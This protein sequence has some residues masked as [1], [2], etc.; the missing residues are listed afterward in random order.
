MRNPT[1]WADSTIDTLIRLAN[2]LNDEITPILEGAPDHRRNSKLSAL[3]S[4]LDG[5][6]QAAF[7]LKVALPSDEASFLAQAL[8][9]LTD[10]ERSFLDYVNEERVIWHK[11]RVRLIVPRGERFSTDT[12][13]MDLS[14]SMQAGYDS[15]LVKCLIS[16]ACPGQPARRRVSKS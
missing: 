8:R 7:S 2:E 15:L 3:Q 9:G 11:G 5:A 6:A 13:I 10:R 14:P 16:P 12:H 1:E 4:L